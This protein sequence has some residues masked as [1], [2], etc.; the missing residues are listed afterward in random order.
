MV[1]C[2]EGS[3]EGAEGSGEGAVSP[4]QVK[5]IFFIYRFSSKG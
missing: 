4:P 2:G 5:K 1:G 3:G